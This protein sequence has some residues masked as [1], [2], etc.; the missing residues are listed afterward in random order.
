M[1]YRSTSCGKNSTH[2]LIVE[3]EVQVEERVEV[4]RA[5]IG[6]V[7]VL[8]L[9]VVEDVRLIEARDLSLARLEP[10]VSEVDRSEPVQAQ[11]QL[12]DGV[13]ARGRDDDPVEL[14]PRKGPVE[15][16][17]RG[18]EEGLGRER[19]RLVTVPEI[20]GVMV[21]L[22]PPDQADARRLRRA[23]RVRLAAEQRQSVGLIELLHVAL[24]PIH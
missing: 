9:D 5:L 6:H 18:R 10:V 11:A 23:I 3:Q 12:A 14:G 16:L 2:R 15:P 4:Q 24:E 20:R 17:R 19:A 1:G 8:E 13:E 7:Q 22:E 21:V